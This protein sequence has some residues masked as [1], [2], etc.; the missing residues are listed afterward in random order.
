MIKIEKDIIYTS[1]EQLL[2]KTSS[3][4]WAIKRYIVARGI[5][6]I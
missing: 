5:V 3:Y 6:E 2:S 4:I 1:N